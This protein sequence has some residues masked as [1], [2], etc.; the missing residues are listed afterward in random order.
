MIAESFKNASHFVKI[1]FVLFAILIGFVIFMILGLI[2]AI[3]AFGIELSALDQAFNPAN[4]ENIG[5]LKFLQSMYSIGLFAFPPIIVAWFFS[6]KICDY[7]RLNIRPNIV[8]ILLSGIIVIVAIPFINFLL[9]MNSNIQFP[10]S[11]SAFED[12][13]EQFENDAQRMTESFLVTNS[14]S[15]YLINLMVLAVIPALGEELLFRGIFQRLFYEW[16]KNVHIAIWV[17][18]FFFSAMHM[19]FYGF[20]PR[21][22]LGAFLGYLFYW[23]GNL[24][25][26]IIAHFLNNAFAIT[27]FYLNNDVS[28]KA[29]TIGTGDGS[30][31]QVLM[32]VAI[33]SVLIYLFYRISKEKNLKLELSKLNE[34]QNEQDR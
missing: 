13:M 20:I 6:G 19:Q 12:L 33:V 18:A 25:I 8:L 2:I 9:E 21:L 7:L 26:P 32:S 34:K 10:E 23:A 17:S 1:I 4:A 15:V 24:W 5:L 11:M 31:F 16:S 3:P 30:N 27:A 29:E 14:F 22:V 28:E